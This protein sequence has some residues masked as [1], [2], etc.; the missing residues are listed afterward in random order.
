MVVAGIDIGSRTTCALIMKGGKIIASE[1]IFTGADSE[2]AARRAM[3]GATAKANL[4][5]QAVDHIMATG[6][7]RIRV[8][9]ADEIV[10]EI[11]C[12][13]RGAHWFF[14][15]V[16]T[17]LD[18]GGQD[19]KAIR[20]DEEGNPADFVMNDKCAAG[21]GRFLEVMAETLRLPLEEIGPLSLESDRPA[22]INSFCTVFAKAE[23]PILIREGVPKKDIL[24]GLHRALVVRIFNL[25]KK[26][27]IRKEFV[28]TGGIARNV[29]VVRVIEEKIGFPA[30]IPED[31]QI[32]GAL[33]AA[34]LARENET[35]W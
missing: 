11:S 34:I 19:C 15:G 4:S 22:T 31:P 6:Y 18:M 13:A 27:G 2:A 5:V 1:M 9:F 32:V 7:G 14:P 29:G 33:G 8:S 26:V 21:T 10:S 24:A 3:E 35:P 25:L 17:V 23:I 20:V 28:I 16:R 12:H 30:L